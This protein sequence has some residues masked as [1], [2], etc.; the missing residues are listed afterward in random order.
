MEDL[1]LIEKIKR[2]NL[3]GRGGANFPTGLKWELVKKAEAAKKYVILNASEGEPFVYKD[4]YILKHFL[5]EVIEGLKL[6]IETVGASEAYIY[7]NHRYYQKLKKKIF[8]ATRGLPIKIFVKKGGY[9]A[10]EETTLMQIIEGKRPEPRLRPP[11]PT[12][13]G[14]YGFPTLINNV[15]TIYYVFKI[16]KNDYY[17]SR[18]VSLSGDLLF[19]GVYELE[20]NLTIKEILEKT[21]N[22]PHEDFFV[23]SGGG[24]SGEFFTS[25]EL[26]KP[27][28]GAGALIV[29]L[30][31][32][33]N[34]LKLARKLVNFFYRENC[35]RCLVCREGVYRLKEIL[36]KKRPDLEK[37]KEIAFSLNQLAF[38]GLGSGCGLALYSL[39]TKIIED[40]AS[41]N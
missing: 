13:E 5:K 37:A 40:G 38:C 29:Y 15:E 2:A 11:Y 8:V 20:E 31:K 26:N 27:L 25:K 18:F 32:K 3:R 1:D 7:L 24:A 19:P 41:K 30:K 16:F 33:T 34:P 22:W 9:L 36:A 12:E 6:A 28:S 10:G 14:L 4:L 35:G 23:Q 39:I 17:Y 21:K